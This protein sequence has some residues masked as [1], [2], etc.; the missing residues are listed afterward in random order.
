MTH[1]LGEPEGKGWGLAPPQLKM[2]AVRGALGLLPE[3]DAGQRKNRAQGRCVST[4]S[5]A[6]SQTPSTSA[7]S[8]TSTAPGDATPLPTGKVPRESQ[9]DALV[10]EFWPQC[11]R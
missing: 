9:A 2:G 3:R 5:S 4:P 6:Q 1:R 7:G 11:C 10:L 8:Q